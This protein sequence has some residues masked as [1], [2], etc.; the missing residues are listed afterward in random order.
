MGKKTIGY[1][2]GG[3]VLIYLIGFHPETSEMTC[4]NSKCEITTKSSIGVTVSKKIQYLSAIKSFYVEHNYER[5]K[6]NRHKKRHRYY[7]YARTQ[8]GSS[9]EFFK[10]STW[11]ESKAENMAQILNEAIKQQP[12]NINIK[13]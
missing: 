1:I 4:V 12:I 10:N 9:F 13:Y 7:I 8:D 5:W 2:F 6:S 3:I 11:S